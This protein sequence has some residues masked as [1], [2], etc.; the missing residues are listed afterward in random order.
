MG[1][2]GIWV[3][4]ALSAL[5]AGAGAVNQ[6]NIAK[7]QEQ[8][9]N[10]GIAQQA[11]RQREADQRIN[12]EIGAQ[13]RSTPEEE[14][15]AS[16]A[17]FTDQLAAAKPAAAG[18]ASNSVVGSDR[19]QTDSNA[20]QA[21]VQ[22]YGAK[23]ADL[24]SRIRA[25]LDQRNNEGISRR[26]AGSDVAGIQRNAEGDAWLTQLLAQSV[27]GNTGLEIGG[28]LATGAAQAMAGGAGRNAGMPGTPGYQ[29]VNLQEELRRLGKDGPLKVNWTA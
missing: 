6:R 7:K 22:N 29:S 18:T 24:T 1:T 21:A 20:A 11:S 4:L 15:A 14:R 13:A 17:A 3:P 2:E 26:R 19:Y 10:R 28:Q 16:L 23:R 25:P 12:A 9:A 27:K 5:G 8:V